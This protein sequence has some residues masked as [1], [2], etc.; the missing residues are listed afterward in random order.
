[1]RKKEKQN[2]TK[3]NKT[4]QTNE[5]KNK[6]PKSLLK[7]DFRETLNSRKEL[8]ALEDMQRYVSLCKKRTSVL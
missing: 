6:T 4:K 5:R 3:V 8:I 1:M 7:P 2:Q